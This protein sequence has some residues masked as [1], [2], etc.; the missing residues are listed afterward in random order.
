MAQLKTFYSSATAVVRDAASTGMKVVLH[1][2]RLHT[3]PIPNRN[4]AMFNVLRVAQLCQMPSTGLTVTG[5]ITIRQTGK[6][7]GPRIG[8]LLIFTVILLFLLIR[9]C[10]M[11]K[12]S[13]GFA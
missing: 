1:G 13:R 12:S 8:F 11:M 7:K 4:R 5:P 3:L 2:P 10:H 6:Q 9:T